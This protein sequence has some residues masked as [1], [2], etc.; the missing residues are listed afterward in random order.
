MAAATTAVQRAKEQTLAQ[1]KTTSESLLDQMDSM[2]DNIA[3][4]A[5]ELFEAN[6]RMFGQDL[7]HWFTAEKE[8]FRPVYTELTESDES[9][10]IKAEVPGFNE[11]E[12]EISVQ[13]RRVVITGKH[14]STNKEQKKDKIVRSETY[15]DQILRIVDLPVEVE[16]DKVTATLKNGVLV[17]AMPKVARARSVRIKPTAA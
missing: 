6:G 13:P 14:E 16:T 11:R 4:R 10:E 5:F 7:E 1:Q 8:L 9:L 3:R 12:L 15:S 17:L 2:F